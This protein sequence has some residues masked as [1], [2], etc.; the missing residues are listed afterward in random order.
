MGDVGGTRFNH[1]ADTFISRVPPPL[2]LSR[3]VAAG[4]RGFYTHY[5]PD[6]N[7]GTTYYLYLDWEN[8]ALVERVTAKAQERIGNEIRWRLI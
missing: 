6:I 7:L 2:T 1:S 3:P 5:S 4:E 8:D